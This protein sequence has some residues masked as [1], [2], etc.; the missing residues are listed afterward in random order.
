MAEWDCDHPWYHGS[1]ERIMI[2]RIGGSITPNPVVARAFSHRPSLVSQSES[3]SWLGEESRLSPPAS[4]TGRE[5]FTSSGSS[6][7]GY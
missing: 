6:V 3:G 7:S 4:K 2:L 1:Q 5:A